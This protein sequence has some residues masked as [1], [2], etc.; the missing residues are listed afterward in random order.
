[1]SNRPP[2]NGQRPPDA[3][4]NPPRRHDHV[5]VAVDQWL[6]GKVPTDYDIDLSDADG[7]RTRFWRCRRCGQERN[8][9][10]EF[11]EPCEGGPLWTP[12]EDGGYS[13]DD[14]RTRRALSEEMEVRFGD[15]GSTYEVHSQSG[16]T[17]RT[18][19][20]AETC[21]CL[22]YQRREVFC[23]HLRR[24]DL[25]IRAGTVPAPNGTFK[26]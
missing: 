5:L 21:T 2:T 12:L 15:R 11:D 18:D 22:D 20:D 13:I 14:P 23:K 19:I 26:R 7:Y 4:T 3:G 6:P 25:E 17:Y 8:R 16:R 1:M 24:V 10:I 9:P